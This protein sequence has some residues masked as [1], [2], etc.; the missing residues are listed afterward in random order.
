MAKEKTVARASFVQDLFQ[1]G[2]YKRNQ[3]RLVRQLTLAALSITLLMAAWKIWAVL[4]DLQRSGDWSLYG[5]A[6]G[7]PGVI[8]LIGGWMAYRLV[9]YPQFADFLIAVEAELSKVS[10]PSQTELIRSSLVVIFMMFFLAGA[11]F[12]FD[13]V[14]RALFTAIGVLE[15]GGSS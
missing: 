4:D 1:A 10:W 7:I 3:G 13:F 5:G 12:G 14:W 6:Y 11:L 8:L 9:N 15:T 2:V